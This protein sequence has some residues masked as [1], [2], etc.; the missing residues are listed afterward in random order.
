MVSTISA[1]NFCQQMVDQVITDCV[2]T[3]FANDFFV[4]TQ[5]KQ[6]QRHASTEAITGMGI[7]RLRVAFG[8]HDMRVRRLP[9]D[10]KK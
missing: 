10:R 3:C 8:F 1:A 4:R 7:L 9:L 6:I 2:G 5:L